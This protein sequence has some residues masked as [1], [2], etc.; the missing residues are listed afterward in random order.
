M[1]DVFVQFVNQIVCQDM[2]LVSLVIVLCFCISNEF[3]D[4]L[5]VIGGVIVYCIGMVMLVKLVIFNGCNVVVVLVGVVLFSDLVVMMVL[6]LVDVLLIVYFFELIWFVVWCIV[7]CIVD[8]CQVEVGDKV[9][10]VY[11]QNVVLVVL[12]ECVIRLVVVVVLGDLIIEGVIVMCGSNGDWLVLLVIC[13]QQ[14][15]LDQVVVVNVGISGN[16]VMDYGCSYS[17]LVWLD[18]DVIVLFNVSKVIVFEGINDICYDGGILFKVGCNVEDMVLG[19]CQIVECLYGNGIGVIVVIII[20]FGGLDCYELLLVVICIMF[21]IWMCG[22]CSGYDV[23]IDFDVVLCDLFILENLFEDII[24]DYLYF[25]DEGY[26]CMV[27]GI[28]LGLFGC[29]V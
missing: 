19:Y 12:V 6:V 17:V 21:N 9:K 5:L 11:W 28:D 18:C 8:G 20:L 14:V 22:G 16:K 10:F 15:C 13:L 27:V 25:N 1:F 4:V 2:C 23:L 7:L 26:W 24:C 29:K 3:G